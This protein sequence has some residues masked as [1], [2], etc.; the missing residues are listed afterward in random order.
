MPLSCTI[1]R[2][3]LAPVS[4]VMRNVRSEPHNIVN[5]W[6][7]DASAFR[8]M[9]PG[10]GITPHEDSLSALV[11]SGARSSLHFADDPVARTERV[12]FDLH[13][14]KHADKEV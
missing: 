14:V 13:V 11:P 10:D 8:L 9:G 5:V 1:S 7:P 12:C 2:G 3:A 4:Y 6:K